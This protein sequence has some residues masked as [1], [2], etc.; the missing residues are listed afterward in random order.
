MALDGDVADGVLPLGIVVGVR[1]DIEA[2]AL[3]VQGHTGQRHV[4]LPADQVGHGA[5]GGVHDGEIVPL[6]IAPDHPFAAG[7]LQLSVIHGAAIR[8]D[9]HVGIVQR[10]GDGVTL[11]IA[12]TQVDAQ[13]AGL[14]HELPQLRPIG[15]QGVVVI[16][17]PVL[18]ACGLAAAH[19]EAEGH[20]EGIAGEE[21][22]GEHDELRPV[23]GGLVDKRQRLFQRAGLVEHDG[24]GLHDGGAAGIF[25]FTH[26]ETSFYRGGLRTFPARPPCRG[27]GAHHRR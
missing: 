4:A 7:G 16:L 1:G 17:L 15:Q 3:L 9:H 12:H 22:L 11:G 13:R 18:T 14:V 10:A 8:R 5:P 6:R 26:G 24:S 2:D 20:A 21:Q 23:P 27:R 19:G 25:Q